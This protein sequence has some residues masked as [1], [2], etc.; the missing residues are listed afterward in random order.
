M[1]VATVD[2]TCEL[3]GETDLSISIVALEPTLVLIFSFA[4]S[5]PGNF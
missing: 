2:D 5:E 1:V 3:C 4:R